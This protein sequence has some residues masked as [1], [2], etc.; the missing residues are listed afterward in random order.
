MFYK[1]YK[2]MGGKE[3]GGDEKCNVA[4]CKNLAGYILLQS[5]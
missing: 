2:K 4:S 3:A 5:N 1:C